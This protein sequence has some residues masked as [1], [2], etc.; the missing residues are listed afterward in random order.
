M[1]ETRVDGGGRQEQVPAVMRSGVRGTAPCCVL[2]SGLQGCSGPVM[3]DTGVPR[4]HSQAF[5]MGAL[6]FHLAFAN[7]L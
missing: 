5:C 4:A 3:F 2:V 6:L 1:A 7:T